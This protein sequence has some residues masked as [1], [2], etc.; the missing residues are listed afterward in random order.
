M[1]PAPPLRE[2][3][4]A[5]GNDQTRRELSVSA[6]DRPDRRGRK[7]EAGDSVAS[8]QTFQI[9]VRVISTENDSRQRQE[10]PN[11][12]RIQLKTEP[13]AAMSDTFRAYRQCIDRQES[14]EIDKAISLDAALSGNVEEVLKKINAPGFGASSSSPQ[15]M[16]LD[17]L[18]TVISCFG[19]DER[20][21]MRPVLAEAHKISDAMQG[22]N[23]DFRPDRLHSLADQEARLGF[24]AE[25]TAT[26]AS[27]SPS[28]A[29]LPDEPKE[30]PGLFQKAQA[31][32][33]IGKRQSR[34]GRSPGSTTDGEASLRSGRGHPGRNVP[35]YSPS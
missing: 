35:T 34:R 16:K 24:F 12:V 30:S 27:I 22:H 31:F 5:R 8:H 3:L 14:P 1:R 2:A 19:P 13:R 9:A 15:A 7:A 18:L 32:V 17:S 26:A 20:E 33:E 4:C 11:M 23:S 25:A 21:R 10:W 6:P 29:E 28:D